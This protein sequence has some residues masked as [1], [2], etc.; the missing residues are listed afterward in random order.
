MSA[1]ATSSR[2]EGS[3]GASNGT[4][5]PAKSPAARNRAELLICVLCPKF[6]AAGKVW[7][8][9][10]LGDSGTNARIGAVFNLT[11]PRPHNN[12]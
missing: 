11:S 12:S 9:Q 4:N 6:N 1:K 10:G 3:Q 5:A 7:A 8:K 2:V